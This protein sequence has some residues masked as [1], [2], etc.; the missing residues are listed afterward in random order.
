MINQNLLRKMGCF[1]DKVQKIIVMLGVDKAIG[2]SAGSRVISAGAGVLSLL[3]ISAYLT[4]EQQGFYFT[5]GSIVALQVFFELGLTNILTQFVAHEQAHIEAE[6]AGNPGV[7]ASRLGHLLHFSV[8]WYL[9]IGL[10][11]LVFILAAGFWFFFR[12]SPDAEKSLWVGPWILVTSVSACNLFMAMILAI[13]K[14]LGLVEE[15]SKITFYQQLLMP[16]T[17]WVGLICGMKLYVVG[18]GYSAMLAVSI[19]G[20][21]NMG[22]HR[23]LSRLWR[24]RVTYK[25]NYMKEIFPY[26]WRISLSWASGYFIFQLFNPVLFATSGS[27]VAGQ[28]GMTLAALNGI[29]AFASSWIDTKVPLLSKYIALKDYKDL[30]QTF[31][32]VFWQLSG[33]CTV[34]LGAFVV[35]VLILERF[36]F[37]LGERFLPML[38]LLLMC[39]AILANQIGNCWATYLRCHKKEPLLVNS[40]VGALTCG[41]ST[42]LLGKFYG[43][44]G[45]T[46]GYFTLRVLLAVWNY[47][48]FIDKKRQWHGEVSVET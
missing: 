32:R 21:L 15:V 9:V 7:H 5:F 36:E 37:K 8:R 45:I 16:L 40:L 24:E 33:V 47:F 35:V 27:V 6:D 4:E 25:I 43:V 34:L 39:G 20:I 13:I 42:V 31:R 18:M 29:S 46:V 38:P 14:G 19:T 41:L 28:M 44:I 11:Y 17:I 1:T 48:V 26:Q 23:H 3:F 12:Y 2:Y 10:F 22:L 30:D